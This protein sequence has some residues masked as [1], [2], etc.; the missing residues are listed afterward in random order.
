MKKYYVGLM[1]LSLTL[2]SGCT[3]NSTNSN[4]DQNANTSNQVN[5]SNTNSATSNTNSTPEIN[6]NASDVS[7]QTYENKA[8]GYTITIPTKW[9]W[10]HFY[11]TEITDGTSIDDYLFVS[12]TQVIDTIEKGHS[13]EISIEVSKQDISA[14]TATLGSLQKSSASVAGESV[15]KYTGTLESGVYKIEYYFTHGG[16]TYRISYTAQPRLTTQ[17]NI[18]DAMVASMTFTK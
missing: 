6:T 4:T 13:S 8:V 7:Y 15:E 9:H 11:K 3:S 2:L 16:N 14:L 1:A 18:F 5:T 17:E 12:P 10:R